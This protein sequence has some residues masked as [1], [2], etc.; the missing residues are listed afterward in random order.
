MASERPVTVQTIYVKPSENADSPKF[1]FP[2]QKDQK[3]FQCGLCSV[4]FDINVELVTHVQEH[5]LTQPFQCGYCKVSYNTNPQLI[6]HVRM[7]RLFV[8]VPF[9]DKTGEVS[10]AGKNG[11]VAVVGRGPDHSK[12]ACSPSESDSGA[13]LQPVTS[14]CVTESGTIPVTNTSQAVH[15]QQSQNTEAYVGDRGGSRGDSQDQPN[16]ADATTQ[17]RGDCHAVPDRVTEARTVAKKSAVSDVKVKLEDG[18]E[19]EGDAVGTFLAAASNVRRESKSESASENRSTFIS[20]QDS[21]ESNPKPEDIPAQNAELVSESKLRNDSC[22]ITIDPEL[23]LE[24]ECKSRDRYE[25]RARKMDQDIRISQ[26]YQ[27][28]KRVT[29]LQNPAGAISE[30]GIGDESYHC[31]ICGAGFKAMRYMKDHERRVHRMYTRKKVRGRV[32]AAESEA[33]LEEDPNS[34]VQKREQ[35][36][37]KSFSVSDSAHSTGGQ[38]TDASFRCSICGKTLKTKET[39]KRHSIT[40]SSDR[41]FL[42]PDCPSRFKTKFYLSGHILSVHQDQ[43]PFSCPHC[44]AEFKTKS[45]LSVHVRKHSSDRPFPCPICPSRFKAK[46][47]MLDHV[48]MVHQGSRPLPC[49]YCPA[50]FNTKTH[51]TRHIRKQHGTLAASDGNEESTGYPLDASERTSRQPGTADVDSEVKDSTADVDSEVK[52]SLFKCSICGKALK[53]KK[54]LKRHSVTHSSDRPFP[55]PVCPSRFKVKS[56]LSDHVV[57]VHQDHRPFPCPHCPAQFKTKIALSGH[58]RRRHSSA[59]PHQDSDR[60]L[61][62]ILCHVCGRSCGS[63]AE[64]KRH[65]LTHSREKPFKCGVCGFAFLRKVSLETHMK[66]HSGEKPYTCEYCG[67]SFTFHNVFVYHRNRHLDTRPL[68]C[69]ICQKGFNSH[70]GLYVHKL[71]HK[72]DR[73]YSCD[74]CEKKFYDSSGLKRHALTHTDHRPWSCPQCGKT[75]RA[76]STLK[77]HLKH[78]H[79]LK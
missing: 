59:A 49:P 3:P 17:S 51:L 9:A 66:K 41:P 39:L 34:S 54:T 52:D 71:R 25:T 15:T 68:H 62:L 8:C 55:C 11:L 31:D 77:Y 45:H 37:M 29:V 28:E 16:M 73:R 7:H 38:M 35:S 64:M 67:Q 13:Q 57:M 46:R 72:G 22:V 21:L 23:K 48:A 75:F 6:V 40:H 47:C 19:S 10:T 63:A 56:H 36:P 5:A 26:R 43:R 53:T 70:P 42:C 69:D 61:K 44:P 33:L 50:G 30:G 24:E 65:L 78:F 1:M 76:R 2:L 79:Q 20:H 74:Q 32:G 60:N 18:L 12:A 14:V 58:V 4:T 27:G